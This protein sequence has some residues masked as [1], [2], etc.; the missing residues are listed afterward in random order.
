V[1]A[2]GSLNEILENYLKSISVVSIVK[3]YRKAEIAGA[4]SLPTDWP[5]GIVQ[6]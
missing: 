2:F 6:W 5:A 4:K 1:L 3:H